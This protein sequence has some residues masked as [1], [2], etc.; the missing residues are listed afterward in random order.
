MAKKVDPL[1]RGRGELADSVDAL[2]AHVRAA[3]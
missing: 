2:A 3:F 1:G